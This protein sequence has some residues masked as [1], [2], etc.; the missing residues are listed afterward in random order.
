MRKPK[1][2]CSYPG[3]PKLVD[4]QYCEEHKKLSDSQY[5]KYGRNKIAQ[6]F[7]D[8][9]EWKLTRKRKL[10]ANPVCEECYSLGKITKAT[11]VDHI[12]PISQGGS[13]LGL[14]NLQSLC[15]QCHS[16]KSAKEGSRWGRK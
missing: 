9:A 14:D 4:G 1:R 11:M 2:P 5:N 8:S 16:T 12:T 15:Y 10:T 7:Y 3:C 13:P 6:G